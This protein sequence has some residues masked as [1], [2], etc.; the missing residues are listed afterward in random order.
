MFSLVIK[1]SGFFILVIGEEE[2]QENKYAD[3]AHLK[4]SNSLK[5]KQG[6]SK[7]TALDT[8]TLKQE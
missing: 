8:S 3:T 7:K 6:L 4:S 2:I 5:Q 1:C